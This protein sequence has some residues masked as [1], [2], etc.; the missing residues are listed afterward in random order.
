MYF[1]LQAGQC[2]DPETF[3]MIAVD[4]DT[5]QD[6]RNVREDEIAPFMQ[7]MAVASRIGERCVQ[8]VVPIGRTQILIGRGQ[9]IRWD[10]RYQ[11]PAVDGAKQAMR[12][13][14]LLAEKRYGR[15]GGRFDTLF[16]GTTICLRRFIVS[17]L[18]EKSGTENFMHYGIV[19]RR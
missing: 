18:H 9:L 16:F 10:M 3:E 19:C 2:F 7:F 13:I 6:I 15:K 11:M 5:R 4:S 8:V 17:D 1:A 14:I 12:F